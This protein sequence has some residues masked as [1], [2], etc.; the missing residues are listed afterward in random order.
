VPGRE[1]KQGDVPG[2]LDGACQAALVR[3]ANAGQTPRHDLAPLGYKSLQQTYVAVRDR[4]DLFGAELAHLL[5]PEELAASAR[6][7]RGTWA[8][9][10]AA[11]AWT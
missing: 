7:A 1:R 4:I 6:T 2:L 10:P 11:G 3:R 8:S 5:A 9:R